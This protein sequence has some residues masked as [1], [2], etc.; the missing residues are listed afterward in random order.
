[1]KVKLTTPL[2]ISGY[3]G[4]ITSGRVIQVHNV[5]E[6]EQLILLGY[7]QQVPDETEVTYSEDAPVENK[8]QHLLSG[9]VKDI[10]RALS[11]ASLTVEQVLE[12]QVAE[13]AGHKRKG[14]LAALGALV[15]TE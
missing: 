12:L 6:A 13:S 11:E 2:L 7:M 1:M 14:V 5:E 4:A 15:S 10:E 9:S 3:R 8:I